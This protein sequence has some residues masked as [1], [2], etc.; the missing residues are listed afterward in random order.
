MNSNV[1]SLTSIRAESAADP[2][3]RSW[4]EKMFD[5]M[6]LDYGKK[7]IDQWGG[8][9]PEKLVNHWAQEMASYSPQEIKRGLAAMEGRDW[10]PTLPEFKKMCRPPVDGAAAYH[11]AVSGCHARDRGEMGMW[12]HPAIFWAASRMAFDL[13]NQTYSSIK[14]QWE[15]ELQAEMD[16]GAWDEIPAPVAALQPPGKAQLS[17]AEAA[18]R[19]QELGASDVLKAKT[20]HKLWA[21]RILKRVAN[22]DRGLS[23]LQVRF[24]EEALKA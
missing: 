24:A 21:K 4:V 6:L 9:D 11:E 15:R 10:P 7:F 22:G 13:K 2:L 12:S 19:L 3:P 20:D 1:R 18:Q 17:R 23:P 8:A 5:K 16:K 14:G